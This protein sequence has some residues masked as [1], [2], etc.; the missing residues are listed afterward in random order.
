MVLTE[1]QIKQVVIDGLGVFTNGVIF[2]NS[3]VDISLVLPDGTK[4]LMQGEWRHMSDTW[5]LAERVKMLQHSIYEEFPDYH[6]CIPRN[7][8]R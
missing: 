8:A 1:N 4:V 2:H 5:R 3:G 6:Y 7:W